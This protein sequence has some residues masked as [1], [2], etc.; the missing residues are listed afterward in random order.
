MEQINGGGHHSKFRGMLQ[1][2]EEV[3]QVSGLPD[4]QS[5]QEVGAFLFQPWRHSGPMSFRVEENS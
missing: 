3:L 4:S 2:D 5:A 1:A